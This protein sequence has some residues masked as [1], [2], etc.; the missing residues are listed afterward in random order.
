MTT[1]VLGKHKHDNRDYSERSDQPLGCPTVKGLV[2]E[3]HI[4]SER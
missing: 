2:R 1:K 3:K 4:R